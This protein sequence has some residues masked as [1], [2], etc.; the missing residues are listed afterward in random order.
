LFDYGI[1]EAILDWWLRFAWTNGGRLFNG[2]AT[3]AIVN[4][5]P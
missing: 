4:S 3:K 1:R 2:D 5:E